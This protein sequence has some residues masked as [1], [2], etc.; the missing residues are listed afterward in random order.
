M[1]WQEASQRGSA[2][3]SYARPAL[4][5]RTDR[6]DGVVVEV[7]RRPVRVPPPNRLLEIHGLIGA[8]GEQLGL[9]WTSER[10]VQRFVQTSSSRGLEH[11]RLIQRALAELV[12]HFVLGCGHSLANL[13]LR[14]LL[15]NPDA[16]T[17]LNTACKNARGF[18]PNSDDRA[19]W[20]TF[21]QN[22]VN[23]VRA[24]AAA[25]GNSAM[26]DLA[27]M[28]SSVHAGAAFRALDDRRGMDYHRRRPQSVKHAS[29]RQDAVTERPDG[30]TELLVFGPN[31][32]D[33]A[34]GDKVHQVVVAALV[35]VTAACRVY[36]ET[37]PTAIR[38]EGVTYVWDW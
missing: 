13:A 20:P 11:Q 17:A 37:M 38:S 35:A 24:A 14:T 19:A 33:D 5:R 23:Y 7:P 22:L 29:P 3:E 6:T 15:L 2:A 8:I 25:S 32:D 26:V 36:R 1:R 4:M 28:V 30:V 12:G 16:R 27:E 34:D 31:S 10:D 18:A 9:A 21:N